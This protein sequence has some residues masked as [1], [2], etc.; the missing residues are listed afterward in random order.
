[1]G[2]SMEFWGSVRVYGECMGAGG[3]GGCMGSEGM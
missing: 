3:L 2:E 1:M